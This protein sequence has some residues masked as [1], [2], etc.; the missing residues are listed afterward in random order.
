MVRMLDF[1]DGLPRLLQVGGRQ[2]VEGF[3]LGVA[4]WHP[5]DRLGMSQFLPVVG[6]WAPALAA[7]VV[8]AVLFVGGFAWALWAFAALICLVYQI[9]TG[10]PLIERAARSTIREDPLH[11]CEA[12][13]AL[14]SSPRSDGG[15]DTAGR[16]RITAALDLLRCGFADYLVIT[17]VADSPSILPAAQKLMGLMGISAPILEFGPVGGTHDEAVAA[18]KLVKTRGWQELLMVTSPA[19][20]RRAA[21]AFEKAGVH[22]VA[23]SS[24]D[25]RCSYSNLSC[26][27][28]RL[29]AFGCWQREFLG[30]ITYR[31]RGWL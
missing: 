14:S 8:G 21:A 20:T 30:W 12:V 27:G 23:A 11:R 5:L 26:P 22:V 13:I 29:Y 17:R 9:I 2:M 18:A 6:K 10:T 3:I 24:E 31:R 4:A 7:G 15:L 16:A 1:Q 19:H 28:D 25:P